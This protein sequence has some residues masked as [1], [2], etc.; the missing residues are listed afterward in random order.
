MTTYASLK[1]DVKDRILTI[2]LNRPER[3]NAFNFDMQREM[4]EVFRKVNDDDEV[5]AVIVTGEGRGFCAGAD[6]G[7]GGSTG[8]G[9]AA[10]ALRL[11]AMP[12]AMTNLAGLY[13]VQEL[14]QPA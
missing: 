12:A 13:G 10:G 6:L 8:C 9:V 4:V 3:L 2:T 11:Q 14:L 1:T 7:A 5:R